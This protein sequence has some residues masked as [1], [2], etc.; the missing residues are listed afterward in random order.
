MFTQAVKKG[1]LSF[2]TYFH[3]LYSLCLS[4]S[5]CLS[6]S[7]SVSICLSLSLSVSL[8]LS[9]SLSVSLCLS[10]S[11]SVSLWL[12][13]SLYIFGFISRLIILPLVCANLHTSLVIILFGKHIFKTPQSLF[14]L[15]SI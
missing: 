1:T 11:L 9:L 6:L 13:R 10:L 7:L 15:F 3:S 2:L 8:C 12:S 14:V 4:V 5:L